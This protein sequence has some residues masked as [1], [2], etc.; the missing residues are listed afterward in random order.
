MNKR[1]KYIKAAIRVSRKYNS[2]CSALYVEGGKVTEL[3]E[4]FEKYFKPSTILNRKYNGGSYNAWWF[5]MTNKKENQLARS[6]ALLFMAEI[7]K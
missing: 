3:Q 6:L 2:C 4:Q 7:E 1:E 5:G